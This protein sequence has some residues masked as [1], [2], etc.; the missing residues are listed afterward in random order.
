MNEEPTVSGVLSL[1]YVPCAID[2]GQI[3]ISVSHNLHT[4][5]SNLYKSRATHALQR[6]CV[7]VPHR[8]CTPSTLPSL[9]SAERPVSFPPAIANAFSQSVISS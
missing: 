3:R 4:P 9:H 2:L 8:R 1:Y 7:C 5:L 6:N